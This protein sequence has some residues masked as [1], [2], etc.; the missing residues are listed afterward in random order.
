M[1][2]ENRKSNDYII[3]II[4]G[5]TF[6][7]KQNIGIY[8]CI[9][10]LFIKDIKKIIKRII[11][12][13]IPNLI[14]LIYLLNNDCLYEFIDYTFLGVSEFAKENLLIRPSC[15]LIVIISYIYIVYKYIKTKDIKLIY[16]F[17]FEL[18]VFPLIE[19]YHVM[20]AIIPTLGYFFNTLKLNKKLLN[21]LSLYL[22]Q[23]YFQ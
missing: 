18:L 14:I 16:L 22:S 7:T 9:P 8:L 2:L 10:T 11:G 5:L 15:L 1:T 23:Q 17:C 19:Q 21:L 13:I 3:G 20:I 12:F 4:L 6:L